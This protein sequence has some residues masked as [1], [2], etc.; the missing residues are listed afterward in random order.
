[1]L[2]GIK[3]SLGSIAYR[4]AEEFASY[5]DFNIVRNYF[6]INGNANNANLVG[7]LPI[8]I[9]RNNEI[10]KIV[11]TDGNGYI[12]AGWIN[13]T[14][15]NFAE[16]PDRI[17]A[18]NDGYIRYMTPANLYENTKQTLSDTL[19]MQSITGAIGEHEAQIRD[20]NTKVESDSVRIWNIEDFF[21]HGGQLYGEIR[22][23]ALMIY[24]NDFYL[25]NGKALFLF[26]SGGNLRNA[27]TMNSINEFAIGYGIGGAGY[28]TILYGSPVKFYVTTSRTEMA[29]IDASGIHSNGGVAAG[30][31]ADLSMS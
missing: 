24:Q 11:R 12:Q 6:D 21:V 3:S 2:G 20:L 7:G 4:E 8:H 27:I 22:V 16:T 5:Y 19:K 30:G 28:K 10:N 25:K 17:Y 14:S 9:G 13:T 29:T 26:D 31:I 23:N 1:M 15:G 18:S